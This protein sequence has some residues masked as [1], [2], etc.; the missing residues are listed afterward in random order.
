MQRLIAW[1]EDVNRI[2]VYTHL[3]RVLA[4]PYGPIWQNAAGRTNPL[5]RPEKPYEKPSEKLRL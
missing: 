1:G 2:A 4:D 3:S 5:P